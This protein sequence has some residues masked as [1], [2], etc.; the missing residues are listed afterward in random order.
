MCDC[1]LL[2]K[3][4]YCPFVQLSFQKFN[5]L[6]L[7]KISKF[8]KHFHISYGSVKHTVDWKDSNTAIRFMFP[9]KWCL[10]SVWTTN[11]TIHERHLCL[12]VY[13]KLNKTN[14][15]RQVNGQAN[16][17]TLT[18]IWRVS[19]G[20]P[21]P[22]AKIIPTKI[23]WLN[24]SGKSPMDIRIPPLRIDI[25]LESSPP[26]STMLSTEIGRGGCGGAPRGPGRSWSSHFGSGQKTTR[27]TSQECRS[28]RKCHW[29]YI[30]RF[31]WESTGKVTMRWKIPLN[32]NPLENATDNPLEHVAGNPRW[33]LRCWF[34][35]CDVLSVLMP[36]RPNGPL[37]EKE[38]WKKWQATLCYIMM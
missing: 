13:L 29:K 8:T 6:G 35:V 18:K 20:T 16:N 27:Q 33:F 5:V 7:L 19:T 3:P 24:M 34:L 31:Q 21:N 12:V 37:T 22:P 1:S 11:L 17:T 36:D 25:M 38:R 32:V 30:G 4:C 23:V 10:T 14:I 26:K 2:Q 28:I 9:D 15:I